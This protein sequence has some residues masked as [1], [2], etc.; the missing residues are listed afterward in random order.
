MDDLLGPVDS[1][2]KFIDDL[3]LEIK[4]TKARYTVYGKTQS[5]P[6]PVMIKGQSIRAKTIGIEAEE[7]LYYAFPE[8][9]VWWTDFSHLGLM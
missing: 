3:D 6:G 1:F 7:Q 9:Y 2:V 4:I 5:K 8:Y